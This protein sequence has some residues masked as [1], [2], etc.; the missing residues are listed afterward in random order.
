MKVISL[1][2]LLTACTTE[3]Y[4]PTPD[5]FG[6]RHHRCIITTVDRYHCEKIEDTDLSYECLMRAQDKALTHCQRLEDF[7]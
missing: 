2:I 4:H 1:L 7:P 3:V 6:E 5:P